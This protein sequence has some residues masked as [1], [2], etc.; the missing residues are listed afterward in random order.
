MKGHIRG[1]APDAIRPI[2]II[3]LPLMRPVND[4][5]MLEVK[6]HDEKA[7]D[8]M[9]SWFIKI[10]TSFCPCQVAETWQTSMTHLR[11]RFSIKA[12][13]ADTR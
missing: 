11:N 8:I 5:A 7:D 1:D 9:Q 2:H 10:Y 3:P 12:N 4:V 6:L 13:H